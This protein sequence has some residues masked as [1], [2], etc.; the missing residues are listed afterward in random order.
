MGDEGARQFPVLDVILDLETHVVAGQVLLEL[1]RLWR[2]K[3][4]LQIL[5]HCSYLLH[6]LI[7][8]SKLVWQCRFIRT[9]R[10]A[11]R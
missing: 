11:N 5:K 10:E 9:D 6:L 3:F 8:R 1:G 4:H 2:V 7:V